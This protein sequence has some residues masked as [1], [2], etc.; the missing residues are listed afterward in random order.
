MSIKSR[1]VLT[2]VTFTKRPQLYN[3]S[4][5]WINHSWCQSGSSDYKFSPFC[6]E[7]TLPSSSSG[8]CLPHSRSLGS[9]STPSSSESD[10]WLKSILCANFDKFW[11]MDRGGTYVSVPSKA[12]S[13]TCFSQVDS[14]LTL[15]A[16][17][18][19]MM[20]GLI[21]GRQAETFNRQTVWD[22]VEHANQCTTIVWIRVN[23][24]KSLHRVFKMDKKRHKSEN[25]S[26]NVE[27]TAFQH[28]RTWF[29]L[30]LII[31][32]WYFQTCTPFRDLLVNLL[33]DQTCLYHLTFFLSDSL[34]NL[35]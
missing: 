14:M 3:N 32:L 23:Q 34:N 11:D 26:T 2:C 6:L 27:K 1:N 28:L 15:T 7:H 24:I 29:M 21:W 4:Q 9:P 35:Q 17:P 25:R 33:D 19:D 12:T 13:C 5:W 8:S 30:T 31:K 10:P 18:P 22:T 20:A 16:G